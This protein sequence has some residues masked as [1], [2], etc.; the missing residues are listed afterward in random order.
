ML[1]RFRLIRAS[2]C[3]V[4]LFCFSASGAV[5]AVEAGGKTTT[6]ESSPFDISISTTGQAVFESEED[7][8]L[9]K[10]GEPQIPWKVMTVLLPPNADMATVSC[11]I[12]SAE[13]ETVEGL[14]EV[15]PVPPL[16]TR[17]AD[18]NEIEE[19]PAGKTIVDG[20]DTDIY[21]DDALWPGEEVQ[22]T[23]TGQL[24][25][26]RLAEIAVPLVRYNPVSGEL[27]KLVRAEI[28][29]DFD[30]KGNAKGRNAFARNGAKGKQRG[31]DRA[32][33]LAV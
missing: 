21:S 10:S 3:L 5:I 2:F 29:V 32:R 17:D 33:K 19:W 28:S 11:S 24:R 18:G 27:Q 16:L 22:L 31:H 14:W 20:H 12:V 15:S 13:C 25:G 26:W 7:G 6:V 1:K 9:S 4:L 23:G 8:C 30:K